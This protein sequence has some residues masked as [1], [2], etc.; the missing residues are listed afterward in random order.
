MVSKVALQRLAEEA[1]AQQI[2]E[3][4]IVTVGEWGEWKNGEHCGISRE[5]GH[6]TF[7]SVR[8]DDSGNPMHVNVWGGIKGSEAFRSFDVGRLQAKAV[9]RSRRKKVVA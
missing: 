7:L 6:F 8:V 3:R 4:G 1:V 9:K 2:A 5:A